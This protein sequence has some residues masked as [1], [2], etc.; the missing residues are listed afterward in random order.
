M[1]AVNFYGSQ[2]ALM[3]NA[4]DIQA[5]QIFY[6]YCAVTAATP[7]FFVTAEK[8]SCN[9]CVDKISLPL[10]QPSFSNAIAIFYVP[11]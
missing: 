3:V 4:D 10:F 6:F 7:S 1:K 5:T 11:G 2:Y 9:T 8:Y